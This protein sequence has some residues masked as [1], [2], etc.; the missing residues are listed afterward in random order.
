MPPAKRFDIHINLGLTKPQAERL[1]RVLDKDRGESRLSAIREAIEVLIKK[2]EADRR[3]SRR[4][5]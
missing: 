1:D 3:R 5:A 2:R 4:S